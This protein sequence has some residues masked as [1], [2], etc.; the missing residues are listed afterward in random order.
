MASQYKE[1]GVWRL[2]S[3]YADAWRRLNESIDETDAIEWGFPFTYEMPL[4]Q[5][6]EEIWPDVEAAARRYQGDGPELLV[7]ESLLRNRLC[8]FDYKSVNGETAIIWMEMCEIC[9]CGSHS[10]VA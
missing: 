9:F 1:E 8:I 10:V 4:E 7:R 6:H 3:D 5:F 2:Q